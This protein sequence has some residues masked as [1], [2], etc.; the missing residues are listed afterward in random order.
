MIVKQRKVIK[1]INI[2]TMASDTQILFKGLG[3]GQF[4]NAEIDLENKKM[5]INS[6]NTKPHVYFDDEYANIQVF[7]NNDNLI[8]EKS[9]IGNEA[10]PSN[11]TI[12]IDVVY[13]I[14]IKL[15]KRQQD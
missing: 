5:A 1:K 14:K 4:A 6:A 11:D 2:N 8:Y 9:Y 15:E 3:D 10:N 12:D 13:K 7:D